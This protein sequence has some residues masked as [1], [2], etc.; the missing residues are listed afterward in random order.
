M[1]NNP[2][3]EPLRDSFACVAAAVIGVD[4]KT[5]KA[6]MARFHD[7]FSRE[8]SVSAGE[9]D[10]LLEAG[11]LELARLD[12]HIEML[13]KVLPENLVER[14]RFMRYFNDC[15]ITDGVDSSEYPLFDKIRD[16]LFTN[17]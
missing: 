10:A 5:T 4:G 9:A 6:E 2:Q 13:A 15:V 14:G 3:L 7:F 17:P 1:Q 12:A 11:K 8:F 16:A